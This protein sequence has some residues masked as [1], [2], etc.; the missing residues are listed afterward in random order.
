MITTATGGY[1][2]YNHNVKSYN[3]QGKEKF[4]LNT[5]Y[6]KQALNK[7]IDEILLSEQI[8]GHFPNGNY[9]LKGGDMDQVL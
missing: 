6:V 5:P 4:V 1:N 7:T 3:V 2:I 8:W 9:T